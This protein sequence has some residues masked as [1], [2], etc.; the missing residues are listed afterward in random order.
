MIAASRDPLNS[1]LFKHG[2][3]EASVDTLASAHIA[4]LTMNWVVID[5]VH[6]LLERMMHE[7]KAIT[8]TRIFSIDLVTSVLEPSDLIR[9]D[10]VHA[11]VLS[12]AASPACT[13]EPDSRID[14]VRVLP[15][16]NRHI[17]SELMMHLFVVQVIVVR[18]GG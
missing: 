3:E 15:A 1:A 6:V 9:S 8:A 12:D 4:L 7:S 18:M 16:L 14:L 11:S 10:A 5:H 17:V 13:E 2:V